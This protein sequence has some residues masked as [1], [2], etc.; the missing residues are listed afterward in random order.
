MSHIASILPLIVLLSG[1]DRFASDF[2]A[3]AAL[4]ADFGTVAFVSWETEAPGTSWVEYGR[5]A[6]LGASTVV[7]GAEATAH[8]VML[9]GIPPSSKV[10]WRAF[11]EVGGEVQRSAVLSIESGPIDRD[12]P[13]IDPEDEKMNPAD[14]AG[15][16]VTTTT[17]VVP[18]Y[19]LLLDAAGELVWALP[20][21][22]D[23]LALQ[24]RPSANG[25]DILY[26]LANNDFS[27]DSSEIVRRR[28]DGTELS[29]TP[30]PNGHHDFVE[31]PGGKFAYIAIDVRDWEGHSVVGDA[32]WEVSE[33]G[34][35][36]VEIWNSW[37]LDFPVVVDPSDDTDLYPQGLDWT[38]CNN[39]VY[40]EA[41]DSYLLS[42][43]NMNLLL[44]IERA[45]GDVIWQ[46]G[47]DGSDFT[48]VG[49]GR[50]FYHQHSP[51]WTEQGLRLFDNGDHE[52]RD[53]YSQAVEYALDEDRMTFEETWNYDAAERHSTYLLGDADGL[54]NGN[55]LISW[56][57]A[58]IITEVTPDE[59]VVWQVGAG[60]GNPLGFTQHVNAI[61]GVP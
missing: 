20:A 21:G 44:K 6:E 48:R 39:L 53:A 4:S 22:T 17:V 37:D 25:T 59:E 56:G 34:T 55:R 61:G 11:S 36:L 27:I 58:G 51:E 24:A 9:V 42:V 26:N 5:T 15:G 43:H 38:H 16:L 33:G 32:I 23:R 28:Y 57:N 49:S 31:L 45:S 10:Y 47:G 12:S 2:D 35:D 19:V 3:T 29:R 41:T 1:C 40:D 46:L 8:E 7:S 18:S 50:D 52:A 14:A 30:T 60:V 13:D 54:A